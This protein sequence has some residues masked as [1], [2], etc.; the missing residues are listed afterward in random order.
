MAE[1]LL[2]KINT[3]YCR[4]SDT[5]DNIQPVL[6]GNA[7][8]ATFFVQNQDFQ[9]ESN[10]FGKKRFLTITPKNGISFTRT[11]PQTTDGPVPFGT[12]DHVKFLALSE[13]IP[14][15]LEGAQ[16]SATWVVNAQQT[17][18]E[19]NPFYQL[20]SPDP[21]SDFRLASFILNFLDFS[22]LAIFDFALTNNTVYVIIER[23]PGLESVFGNYAAYEYAIP[24]YYS[25]ELCTEWHK[26]SISYNKCTGEVTWSI[27]EQ[28]VFQITEIGRLLRPCNA[29][30]FRKG[31]FVPLKNPEFYKTLDFGGEEPVI[32]LT[33]TTVQAGFGLFTIL[34]AYL[35]RGRKCTESPFYPPLVRLESARY[36][37]G[38]SPF[39]K[40]PLTGGEAQF[41]YNSVLDPTGTFYLPTIPP[42]IRV[43]GQ[44]ARANVAQL[45]VSVKNTQQKYVNKTQALIKKSKT[46]EKTLY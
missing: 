24:V 7:D 45:T 38:T 5:V 6:A 32:P 3:K 42:Q 36:R 35:P 25:K 9:C 29:F 44:G 27:D 15:P 31:R 10:S 46:R 11:D 37:F 16:I 18:V 39:Y 34:D 17:N 40:N 22:K 13:P 33:L 1:V 2:K 21:N 19:N 43:F 28:P 23:L 20:D 30:I 14:A 4:I 26:Y 12:T 8:L 41:L